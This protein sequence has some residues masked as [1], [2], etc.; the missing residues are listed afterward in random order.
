[1]TSTLRATFFFLFLGLAFSIVFASPT[2]ARSEGS[3]GTISGYAWSD[4]IGWVSLRG[5]TYGLAVASNG[6]LSGYAW[7]DNLGWI[8][9]NPSDLAGCPE[10]PCTARIAD[11]RI[12]GWLRALAGGSTESGGWD[13]FISLSGSNYG[14]TQ[15]GATISG[16]AWGATNVG[17]LNFDA[18]TDFLACAETQ[19]Y[20]CDGSI[21]KHRD[22]QC[23]VTATQ[24]SYLCA[25]DIGI[26]VPPPAPTYVSGGTLRIDPR[27]VNHGKTVKV[28]WAVEHADT[29]TV[30]ENNP[31]IND[32][33]SGITSQ[34]ATCTA[35]GNGCKS[36][37]IAEQT[38]YTLHCTGEGGT[39]T[40]TA[41]VTLNPSWNER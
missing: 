5:A 25:E 15:S 13:G 4:T 20:F 27:I 9:A 33:W 24:C 22:S 32:S 29:C 39:F 38:T 11:G 8:S 10:S 1:M 34:S 18:T 41:T 31:S 19:G 28:S 16:Y 6:A 17:W 36:S 2:P 30:T 7:S 14:V 40:D 23:V 21:S 26:C 37:E 35:F 12:L 3:S